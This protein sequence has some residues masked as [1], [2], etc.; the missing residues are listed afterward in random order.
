MVIFGEIIFYDKGHIAEWK[1]DVISEYHPVLSFGFNP[2]AKL[3]SKLAVSYI[4][5]CD[6]C[7]VA[8]ELAAR[9][10]RN[11]IVIF[12]DVLA[13][14]RVL[15]CESWVVDIK[16]INLPLVNH[17]PVNNTILSERLLNPD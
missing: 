10:N 17:V 3:E 7:L 16:V 14:S 2:V 15:E 9:R 6:L 8:P 12:D 11:D 5:I 4:K 1:V 13:P